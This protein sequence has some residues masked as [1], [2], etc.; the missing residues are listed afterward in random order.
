MV[1]IKELAKLNL[2]KHACPTIFFIFFENGDIINDQIAIDKLD[3]RR[4]AGSPYYDVS[5]PGSSNSTLFRDLPYISTPPYTRTNHYFYAETYLVNEVPGGVVDLETGIVKNRVE[6]YSGVR[7]GWEN[8]YTPPLDLALLFDTTGSMWDDLD[9]VKNSATDIVNQL[10]A[11]IPDSRVAIADYRDFPSDIYG[12]Y[13]DYPYNAVLPFSDKLTNITSAINSV[14]IGDGG[15]W[16]ESAYSGL[17]NVIK[18]NGIGGWRDEAKK[19]IILFTDAPPHDPEPFTSYTAQSIIDAAKNPVTIQTN[20]SIIPSFGNS[21]G[22]SPFS[23]SL[24]S[25]SNS[26]STTSP[27]SIYSVFLGN[28]SSGSD[29]YSKLSEKTG[30]KLYTSYNIVDSLFE[31]LKDIKKDISDPDIKP[32]PGPQSVPE[33][34]SILGLFVLSLVSVFQKLKKN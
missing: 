13:G 19:A 7:W 12:N 27:V 14:A 1:A 34:T 20:S 8:T 4:G 24:T 23:A 32:Q 31:V 10:F 5:F 22:F 16:S 26:I 30:G 17:V 33:P 18:G 29:Y 25:I 6:I 21:H 2:H 28:D 15:D 3:I 9:Q 11:D